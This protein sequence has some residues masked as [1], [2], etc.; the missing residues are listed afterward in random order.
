MNQTSRNFRQSLGVLTAICGSL[1]MGLSFIPQIAK[2]QQTTPQ[3]PGSATPG[4]NP[5]PRI[6]YE[7][8]YNNRVLVPQGCPPNAITQQMLN[9]GLV[10]PTP[11]QIRQGVGG[12]APGVTG[13]SVLNPNPRIFQ[14]APYNRSQ[15]TLTTPGA[16]P[17]TPAPRSSV[18]QPPLPRQQQSA[19]ATVSP[20][21]NA[22]NIRLVND[23][24]ANVTYQVIG[25]TAPRSLAG[26]SAV[27]LQ[28]VKVPTT[29]TFYRKDGGLLTV[30]AQRTSQQGTL[31]VTLRETPTVGGDKSVLRIAENGSV[32]LN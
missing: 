13:S 7:E 8:P 14:E 30:A 26:K 25:D 20:T 17:V 23:S 29:L 9:Q 19:I 10:N 15:Q 1:F 24:G 6:F 32:Y 3:Q 21:N 5:C 4:V 16:L 27:T 31:S 18:I 28:G 11:E 22:V 2:A 12:E